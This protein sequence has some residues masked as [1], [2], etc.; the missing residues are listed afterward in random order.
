MLQE[1]LPRYNIKTNVKYIL[2]KQCFENFETLLCHDVARSHLF[3]KQCAKIMFDNMFDIN[4]IFWRLILLNN[5]LTFRTYNVKHMFKTNL[6]LTFPLPFLWHKQ[7]QKENQ[8]IWNIMPNEMPTTNVTAR[9]CAWKNCTLTTEPLH[10]LMCNYN[11]C[12][13]CLVVCVTIVCDNCWL[14]WVVSV[15]RWCQTKN[16][17]K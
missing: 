6:V 4:K 15:G 12:D 5:I 7:C 1:H 10:F 11:C 14:L 3:M 8:K 9:C 16:M 2:A 13:N 17:S